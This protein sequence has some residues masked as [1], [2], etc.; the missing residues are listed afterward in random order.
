MNQK[1]ARSKW[2]M[3]WRSDNHTLCLPQ[4][5]L[6]CTTS[7]RV[8]RLYVYCVRNPTRTSA[9]PVA[10]CPQ[11]AQSS[12][13]GCPLS[14]SARPRMDVGA[15]T[16]RTR[17]APAWASAR[18]AGDDDARAERCSSGS[19]KERVLPVPVCA[20]PKTSRPSITTGIACCCMGV[21]CV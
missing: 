9:A 20:N 15:R 8:G 17:S 21:G 18:R 6:T 2:R 16:R 1:Q 14:Q 19:R 7:N 5:S 4:H 13:M 12:A 11:M 3:L 10:E